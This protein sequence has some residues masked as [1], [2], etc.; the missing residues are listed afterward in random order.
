MRSPAAQRMV[1]EQLIPRGVTDAAVLRAML[2]VPREEFVP[3]RLR[4]S[5]YADRALPIGREQTISQPLVVAEM[6]QALALRPEHTVLEVGGGSG[7]QAAVLSRLCA[8]VVSVE[9]EPELAERAAATLRRLGYENVEVAIGDG[10]AG[11]PAAAPFDAIL[12]ACAVPDL[13]PALLAQLRPGGRIVIP[14]GAQGGEQVLKLVF[15]DG[16]AKDLFAVRFVPM[17]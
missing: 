12:V 13:P 11:W 3:A 17:R 9:L 10:S 8:R 15:Q 6:T 4:S 16:T 1:D 7:Y 2:E 5:A 14:L